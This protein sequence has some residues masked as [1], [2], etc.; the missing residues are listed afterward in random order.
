MPMKKGFGLELLDRVQNEGIIHQELIESIEQETKR[1]LVCYTS[2]FPHPAG[3][4]MEEDDRWIETVLKSLDL[5]KFENKLDLM[6]H[7]RGGD[8]TSAQKIV[9]TCRT[10]SSGF[11]VIVAKTAMSAGTLIAMA[12]DSIVMRET[13][14][15]GPIDPQMFM[16]TPAGDVLRP[17][18]AW[19]EAYLDLINK[20]QQSIMN[21]KPPHPYLQQLASMDPTWIQLCVKARNLSRTIAEG[22]LK[23]YMLRSKA[24][25]EIKEIVEKFI[26]TGEKLAHGFAIRP[27]RAK[28]FG[29][30]EIEVIN[31]DSDLDKL[32]WELLVRTENYVQ[33]KHLA[34][35][36]VSRTGGINVQVEAVRILA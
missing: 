12:G 17:A 16:R 7:T 27:A 36:I 6:I 9:E 11:R 3:A 14:E 30:T 34:K 4:I 22:Y 35:Y 26:T 15:L 25:P 24:E 1:N 2:N 18:S 5:G 28:E 33:R 29:L 32:I 20:A 23:E 10:Y 31:K 19:V 8:P 13:S 21:N